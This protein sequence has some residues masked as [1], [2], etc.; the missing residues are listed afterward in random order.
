MKDP[1]VIRQVKGKLP[2]SSKGTLKGDIKLDE[3]GN[4]IDDEREPISRT[5]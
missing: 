1:T 5:A 4:V 3:A 2:D